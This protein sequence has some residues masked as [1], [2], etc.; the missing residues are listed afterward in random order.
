MHMQGLVLLAYSETGAL[1]GVCSCDGPRVTC[2]NACGGPARVAFALHVV[3]CGT[4]SLIQGDFIDIKMMCC[5]GQ[6]SLSI[7]HVGG[8]IRG[9]QVRHCS[10]KRQNVR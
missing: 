7:S 9:T 5:Q 6:G 4:S 2:P 1:I 10:L 8:T 3:Y